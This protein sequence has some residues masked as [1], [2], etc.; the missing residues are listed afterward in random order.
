MQYHDTSH[1]RAGHKRRN[2]PCLIRPK[3]CQRCGGDLSL[4]SDKY[5][6]YMDC[7]QCGAMWSESE[8][9]NPHSKVASKHQVRKPAK[10]MPSANS[11]NLGH[12]VIGKII[13]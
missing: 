6:S 4:E 8:L 5:G 3:A 7:I 9:S 2:M 12:S 11:Y 1:R 13:R 10:P